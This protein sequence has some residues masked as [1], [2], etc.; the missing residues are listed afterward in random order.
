MTRPAWTRYLTP[1]GWAV[2][3]GIAASIAILA[4][5]YAAIA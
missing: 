3:A 2:M 1:R 5:L 4:A